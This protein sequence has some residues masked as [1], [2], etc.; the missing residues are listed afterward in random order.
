MLEINVL[1][2]KYQT[3][4][5]G[6]SQCTPRSNESRVVYFRRVRCV[7][8]YLLIRV[9]TVQECDATD[10]AM[11][12]RSQANKNT[13]LKNFCE[14]WYTIPHHAKAAT[15]HNS[16]QNS[17]HLKQLPEGNAKPKPP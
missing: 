10:D 8:L 16:Q 1:L 2:D 12:N 9:T 7:K 11:K 17:L 15:S 5:G 4:N 14:C 3:A 6:F 13:S